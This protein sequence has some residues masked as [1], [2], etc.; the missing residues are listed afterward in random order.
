MDFIR[1]TDTLKYMDSKFL[2]EQVLVT[3][4]VKKKLKF[5]LLL[6]S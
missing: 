3:G 2:E 6:R 5:Y 4:M 1:C